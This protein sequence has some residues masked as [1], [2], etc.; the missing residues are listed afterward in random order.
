MKARWLLLL[1]VLLAGAADAQALKPSDFAY[2]MELRV[3]GADALVEVTLPPE[4]YRAV[5]RADLGDVR[6]F[7]GADEVVAH[8][9]RVPPP[10]PAERVA[11]TPPMF[12]IYATE[13]E[14]IDAVVMNVQRDAQGRI[15]RIETR[16]PRASKA[17]GK[18]RIMAYIVDASTLTAPLS[19]VEFEW[20]GLSA[21]FLG[22]FSMQASDDLTRWS[23]VV[24]DAGIA[25]LEFGGEQL[26]RRRVEFSPQR[27]KYYRVLWPASKPLPD[28]PTIKFEEA[29]RAAAPARL[30]E[31][32]ALRPGAAAGEFTFVLPGHFPADRARVAL[33]PQANRVAQATLQARDGSQDAWTR[34]GGGSV[35]RLKFGS[36]T[37]DSP[38][39]LLATASGREWML[40]L[41]PVEGLEKVEPVVELGWTPHRLVFVASGNGAFRLAYG[42]ANVAPIGGPLGGVLADIEKRETGA[43]VLPATLGEQLVLGGPDR[44]SPSAVANWRMWALWAVLFVAVGLLAWMAWTLGRRM[45]V[46]GN[47][48]K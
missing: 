36:V 38:E 47:S 8:V 21:G 22:T 29:A 42:A 5:T 28:L 39:L 15:A 27:A 20:R 12:P 2:G 3:G 37:V 11:H 33:L 25:S 7:N 17:G 41:T 48:L 35:Y 18:R 1:T 43:T 19:A 44:L 14:A 24:T 32:V 16:P 10:A 6:V 23:N 45:A 4:V 31:K 9:L 46:S 40:R 34:R 26:E 30:W 13:G